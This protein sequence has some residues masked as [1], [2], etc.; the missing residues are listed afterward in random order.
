VAILIVVGVA[1]VVAHAVH[2]LAPVPIWA[3]LAALG[4]T[5]ALNE[6]VAVACPAGCSPTRMQLRVAVQLLSVTALMYATGLG[7]VLAVGYLVPIAYLMEHFGTPVVPAVAT[8]SAVGLAAGQVAVATGLAPSVLHRPLSNG[9]AVLSG[10]GLATGIAYLHRAVRRRDAA[11]AAMRRSEL[12]FRALAQHTSD[13]IAVTNAE[14]VVLY[15]SPAGQR[16]LGYPEGSML[17]SLGL[18]LV[19][20][21]DIGLAM[22]LLT[23]CLE[24]PGKTVRCEVRLRHASGAWRYFELV[25]TNL[26]HDPAI[27]GIVT[28]ARDITERKGFE[29]QLL[30]QALR[31]P[32]TGLPNRVLFVDRLERALARRGTSDGGVAVLLLDLDRFKIVND[33]LGH[34]AGDQLLAEVAHRLEDCLRPEDTVARL[35]GDEF[36]VLVDGISDP[37]DA[38]AV[39]ERVTRALRASFTLRGH[40]LFVAASIGI[41]LSRPGQ[42]PEEV[43]RDADV[44]MYLAK[45]R[46][47]A[48]YELFDADMPSLALRRLETES[49]LRRALEQD[50]LRVHYQP[51]VSIE[52]GRVVGFEALVRWQHPVRGLLAPAEFLPVAE[53]TGLIAPLGEWVLGE[54]CRQLRAWQ[55]RY[56]GADEL[57]MSVNLSSRQLA[58]DDLVEEVDRIL[59]S[60]GV[61]PGHLV[62]EIT[63]TVVMKDTQASLD[64]LRRLRT[65]G[66]GLAID[67]FGTGYSSFGNLKMFPVDTLKLD[68]TFVDSLADHVEGDVAIVETVVRLAHTLGMQ[69]V[70][71]GVELPGQLAELRLTGCDVLQGFHFARPLPAV[72]VEGMLATGW[73][74]PV[75]GPPLPPAEIAHA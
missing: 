25:S 33:S 2:W 53:E 12:R 41:A 21:E 48:R 44:A 24:E 20:P 68:K 74:A 47:R 35:G 31:D 30:R 67:D 58:R 57:A 15:D 42:G 3:L 5:Y 72:A 34:D 55:D 26:L 7:A 28:N 45:D 37:T 19:H 60:S 1:L 59:R 27:G 13:L 23:R 61:D 51:M 6:V 54:S 16:L 49:D 17:G 32:L 40:D 18:D 9:V 22:K 66:V 39:A 14:G 10:I 70:A 43:L 71:E 62:L 38:V 46:G 29:D 63:E 56:P 50:E 65:L 36:T 73:Q 11:E 69:V 75:G 64:I 4:A 8:W 52:N